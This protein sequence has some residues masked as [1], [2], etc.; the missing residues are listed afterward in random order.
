MVRVLLEHPA[1]VRKWL[2]LLCLLACL[3]WP[4]L[5]ATPGQLH[6]LAQ[7]GIAV[8]ICASYGLLLGQTGLLS[9]GHAVYPALGGYLVIYALQHL[10]AW[11][12]ASPA[13]VALLPLAAGVGVVVVAAVLGWPQVR[14]AGT[15]FGM[16]TLGVGELFYA[17]AQALPIL[18]GGEGGQSGNR[19]Q[20][21]AVWGLNFASDSQMYYLVAVYLLAGL[22]LYRGWMA[23]PL[24]RLM[25]AVRDNPQRVAFTGTNP[26]G[27]RFAAV[28]VS[29][30]LAGVAGGLGALLFETVSPEA[31]GTHRSAQYLVFAVLGGCNSLFGAALGGVLMVVST[32]WLSTQTPAWMLYTGLLFCLVVWKS[33]GG[34]AQRIMAWRPHPMGL[35]APWAGC[36][37]A[38]LLAG[39]GL[40][41]ELAYQHFNLSQVAA[42]FTRM[43]IGFSSASA[44]DWATAVA[45]LVAGAVALF[46]HPG[47]PRRSP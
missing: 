42:S 23:T 29:A 17:L 44:T 12:W 40:L 47:L 43:G 8:L 46:A 14:H 15:V 3:A 18:T 20:G 13:T 33:P 38:L 10:G 2:G 24:G 6:L 45:L 9:F 19:V 25:N 27:V 34:L 11:G 31:F 22:A 4:W 36:A 39:G 7:M 30:F 32:V 28:L 21:H 16:V 41:V 5:G 37:W 26:V 35:T 1:A